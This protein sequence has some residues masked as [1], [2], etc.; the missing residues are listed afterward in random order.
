MRQCADCFYW[1]GDEGGAEGECRFNPPTLHVM[2]MRTIQGDGVGA[3][4]MVPRTRKDF[5]CGQFKEVI[6]FLN[7]P[8]VAI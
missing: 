4:P 1:A 5:W 3:V 2:P 6:T 8:A 7:M